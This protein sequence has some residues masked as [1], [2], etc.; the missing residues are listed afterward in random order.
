[1]NAFLASTGFEAAGGGSMARRTRVGSMGEHTA[2]KRAETRR[3]LPTLDE[4][5]RIIVD[6]SI[7]GVWVLDREGHT[8]LVNRRMSEMLGFEEADLRSRTF[9]EL[10]D[11]DQVPSAIAALPE[12]EL[13]EREVQAIRLQHRDGHIVDARITTSPLYDDWHEPAGALLMVEDLT[14]LRAAEA[15][16]A[17]ASRHFERMAETMPDCFWSARVGPRTPSGSRQVTVTYLSPGC[18]RIWGLPAEAL[19]ERVA[20]WQERIVPEDRAHTE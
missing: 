8:L 9:F 17:E 15:R 16:S 10:T 18:Q 3:S 7:H 13:P 6:T 4:L 1:M 11:S 5:H 19:K 12:R 2:S 20:L 14:E